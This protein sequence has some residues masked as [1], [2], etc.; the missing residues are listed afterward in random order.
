[1]FAP[2]EFGGVHEMLLIREET[3]RDVGQAR[4]I[5]IAAFEQ[6]DELFMIPILDPATMAGAPGVAAIG[7]SS[8]RSLSA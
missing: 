7:P 5:N 2:E 6:P 4:M 1:V 3:P 8:T